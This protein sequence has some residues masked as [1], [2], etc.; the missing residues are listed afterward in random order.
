MKRRARSSHALTLVSFAALTTLTLTLTGCG[1][2]SGSDGAS[3]PG[4]KS[5]SPT[6][7]ITP[8]ERL[9]EL[10][11]TKADVSGRK[12]DKPDTEYLFATSQ[13]EVSVDKTSCAPL[14]YAMNQLPL[15]KPEADLTRVVGTGKY[16]DAST[17][18]TLATYA[19][20]EAKSAM[21]GLSK[22][23]DACGGGFTA[24]AKNN[25]S[26]YDSVSSEKPISSAKD[27]LAF[28]ST[29]SF[30]GATHTLHT[31]AVRRDD[32]VA[33]YFS[34]NGFAI[35]ESKPSDAKLPAEVVRAQ[36]AKLE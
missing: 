19:P 3:D 20:G 12:V 31:E 17:Y 22:A 16:G 21:A 10:M 9:A 24:K 33:V 25:T 1:G 8:A 11:I 28:K 4:A 27:S 30:R 18:V 2:G 36:G 6:K 32:V 15:G 35:A 26:A 14:A 23:V 5:A 29:L 7:R 13:D 34:V